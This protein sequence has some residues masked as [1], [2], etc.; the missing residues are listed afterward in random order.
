MSN[1]FDQF[2]DAP[3]GQRS[4]GNI[5]LRTRPVVKNADGSIS[6][7][8]SISIG[9]D[10]G[11]VVIPTVSED[12]RIMSDDEAIAQYRVTGRNLGVFDTPE[13]ATAYAEGLHDEQA[14]QYA[15]PAEA[16]PFDQFEAEAPAPTPAPQS[17]PQPR[18]VKRG[19]NVFGEVAGFMANVNRGLGVADELAAAGGTVV[20]ALTG[21]GPQGWSA[22]MAA[23]RALEDD[24]RSDRPR[25][26]ALGTGT[27]NALTMAAPAGPGAAAFA[28][29][30]RVV[31]ALRGA[32]VA[33]LSG[34]GYSAVDR[35]TL[36]ERAATAAKSARDPLTLALGSG[37]GAIATRGGR[38][39]RRQEAPPN[40]E[41]LARQRDEA[42][43]A[44]DAAG[45]RYSPEAFNRLTRDMAAAVDEA[46]FHGGLHPKTA[47]MLERLGRSERAIEGGYSPSLQ[48][49][50]QL[51]QQ[52]GRDVASSPD[53]GERRMGTILRRQID[54]FIEAEGGSPD[55][56]RARDLNTRVAKLREL[57]NLDD[58]AADRTGATGSGGNINNATRQN[59]IRFQNN[60]DNLTPDEQA[61]SR[62]VIRGTRTGNALRLAGKLSPTG[63]GLMAAGHLAA[64]L[65]THGGSAVVGLG[66]ALS[67]A[68]SDAITTR[69]VQA[70]RDLIASGGREAAVVDQ[71]LIRAGADD[72]RQQLANDLSVA[73]GVQGA[74]ARAPIE[75]DVSR[76]TNPEHLAW[77]AR[78][79]R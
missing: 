75:I 47:A 46:G 34:A 35:G 7:V 25:M 68:A 17:G 69:N 56:L 52:I 18:R 12:G 21:R 50:D 78:N 71:M 45:E 26:A 23:Q 40:V 32:T 24:F 58:A 3:A 20:N 41:Q 13:D 54:D 63:N 42:Y 2:D 59:V 66:G 61:A 67:K 19:R 4:V 43:A 30:G 9:T 77:R 11:E 57:D 37:A 39:A 53:A 76:S 5:D 14:A 62:R 38:R 79:G 36:E 64:I 49:L 29:G 72:L 44:V 73:A 15:A 28:S 33:G 22:N 10:Q 65:P 27:G 31:N 1:P 16:N 6:T 74:S 48:E 70:L 55:L 60:V 51:R 8:R